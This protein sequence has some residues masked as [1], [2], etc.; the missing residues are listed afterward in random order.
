VE[1]E[2]IKNIGTEGRENK[3]IMRA[4]F[5]VLANTTMPSVLVES[6]F[7]TNEN[8]EQKLKD[9]EFRQKVA[10]GICNG[11]QKFSEALD[12]N[13]GETPKNTVSAQSK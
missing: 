12:N 3:K 9:P 11:L 2:V 6:A 8:E 13:E 1:D 5:Y 10:E 7:I 4:P